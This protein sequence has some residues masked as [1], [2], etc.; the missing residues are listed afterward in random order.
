MAGHASS[1]SSVAKPEEDKA[2]LIPVQV[3]GESPGGQR[4]LHQ[5]SRAGSAS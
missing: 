3:P 2:M 5:D 1:S 4:G